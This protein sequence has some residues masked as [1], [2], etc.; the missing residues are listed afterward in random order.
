MLFKYVVNDWNVLLALFIKLLIN[1]KL[2][3][4][5]QQKCHNIVPCKHENTLKSM[6]KSVLWNYF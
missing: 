6:G 1:I 4:S 3:E 2:L 5:I